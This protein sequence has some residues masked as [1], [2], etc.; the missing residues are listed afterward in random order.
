MKWF[1]I[2]LLCFL[3]TSLAFADDA[4][5]GATFRQVDSKDG[6]P[7]NVIEKGDNTKPAILFI[8]GFRQSYLSWS[9]QFAS[10][11]GERCHLVAFDLRG[12]GN[13]GSPWRAEAYDNSQPWADDVASVIKATGLNKPL[14]VAWSYGGNV[15][16][17][18]IRNYPNEKLAGIVMV[19]TSAGTLPISAPNPNAPPRPTQSSDLAANITAVNA[20]NELLF[21]NVSAPLKAQF[22]LA[23][24]RVSPFVE[25]G[26]VKLSQISNA[27]LLPKISAPI[28]LIVGGKDPIIPAAMA[29]TIKQTFAHAT[30]VDFPQSGHAPFLD[31]PEKFNALL[32]Q[33]QCSAVK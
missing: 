31:E 26:I 2:V 23:A 29:A 17:S 12:H 18:F 22:A 1:A 32:D 25:R 24:M 16:M 21:G 15:T 3:C 20:A 19:D 33:L 27:D 6:V 14:I 30:I 10:S 9:P 4:F 8:H 7:L 13:S 28:T 5:K 11:L